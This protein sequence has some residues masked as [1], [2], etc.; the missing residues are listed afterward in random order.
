MSKSL[1]R[2]FY[3]FGHKKLTWLAPLLLLVFMILISDYP[4]N[5]LLAMMTYDSTDAIMIILV[6]VGATMFS[7]E[8]QN[9]AILTL[10]YKS[11]RTLSVYLDKFITIFIYNLILH[12]LAIIFTFILAATI[13]P[14]SWSAAYQYHQPL[15]VNMF[16]AT[17]VDILASTL[18]IS[19]VFLISTLINSNAVVVTAGLAVMFFG[20]AISSDITRGTSVLTSLA[21]WN[22]FNMTMLTH[23]YTNYA[24][25]YDTTLLSNAQLATGALAY[26]LVFFACGYLIFRKKRF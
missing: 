13:N 24:G 15:I 19:V 11:P 8:F 22:P 5:R 3:K 12:G 9:N 6:I 14:V 2:E 4:S 26:I 7:M 10:L 21:K 23:Q 20:E 18:I 1:Y 17:G 25:Y 16:L